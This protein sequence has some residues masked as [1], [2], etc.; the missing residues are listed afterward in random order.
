[1]CI[2]DRFSAGNG[3][4]LLDTPGVLWPKFDDRE[5]GDK[6]AFIGSVKDE[7]TDIETIEMCIRD[8]FLTINVFSAKLMFLL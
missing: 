8:R 5:V 4:E 3:I 7:V 6:L 2:R 1:M